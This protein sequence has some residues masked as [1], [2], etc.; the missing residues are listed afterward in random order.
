MIRLTREQGIEGIRVELPVA[1][2]GAEFAVVVE[3]RSLR[4][5]VRGIIRVWGMF[6]SNDA[7]RA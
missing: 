2:V 5:R 1:H 7:Q 6:F 4:A 3:A